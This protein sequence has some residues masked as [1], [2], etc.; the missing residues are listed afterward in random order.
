MQDIEGCLPVLPDSLR[1]YSSTGETRHQPQTRLPEA[2]SAAW[3]QRL[4]MYI[5]I[6]NPNRMSTNEGVVQVMVN[7]LGQTS[8]IR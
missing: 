2:V 5:V 6:S 4:A 1:S 7:L 3:N 8:L